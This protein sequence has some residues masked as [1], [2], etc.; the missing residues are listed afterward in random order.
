MLLCTSSVVSVKDS[1]VTKNISSVSEFRAIMKT[2]K[3][4]ASNTSFEMAGGKTAVEEI[5]ELRHITQEAL[6]STPHPI[7]KTVM[8]AN[9]F[10]EYQSLVN[11]EG[12]LAQT[13]EIKT[14]MQEMQSSLAAGKTP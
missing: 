7:M 12:H 9:V 5:R 14:M 4:D 1:V 8:K 3:K 13:K 6:A 10:E 11:S 2:L